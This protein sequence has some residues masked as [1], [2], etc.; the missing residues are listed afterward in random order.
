MQRASLRRK[1]GDVRGA[2]ND[3]TIVER[4]NLDISMGRSKRRY[5]TNKVRLRSDHEL[6]K[7]Q[8]LVQEDPD[9]VRNLFGTLY[10][11][12]QNEKVTEELMHPYVPAFHYVYVQG[13]HAVAF[14]EELNKYKHANTS[15]RIFGLT[16]EGEDNQVQ[17]AE[18]DE[19]NLQRV[20]GKCSKMEKSIFHAA[21]SLA[22]YDYTSA[23]NEANF[24]VQ[25]D[26]SSVVALLLR[27]QVSMRSAVASTTT[28]SQ[29]KAH[30]AMA[31]A[32]LNHA[33]RLSP[34]NAYV[35]YNIGCLYAQQQSF[36]MAID[37]FTSA[38]SIDPHL[39][40]AYYNRGILYK[41][42]GLKE[43]ANSDFSKAGQ[44]GLYKA[45]AMLKNNQ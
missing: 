29:R 15:T 42:Q 1:I 27:S 25:T 11:K 3:E 28:D 19:R 32:D 43:K 44:L 33:L 6:D 16:A 18:N 4:R 9:T 38:I 23:L 13:Y 21:I 37:A 24:A 20:E 10:G 39:P 40:E 41:Q 7:Y 31:H 45:Y 14:M 34:K 17:C 22:K 5:A 26:T 30:F 8:Q 35:H 36:V 2:L 12:V